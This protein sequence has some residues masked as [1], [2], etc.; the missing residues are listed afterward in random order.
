[1]SLLKA[2]FRSSLIVTDDFG[3]PYELYQDL[4]FFSAKLDREITVPKKFL[5]DL[6]SIP[7]GLWNLLPKSGRYDR[8]AVIHDWLYAKNGCTRAEADAILKEAMEALGV[9]GV[10]IWMIYSG[11]RAGGWKSWGKYRE[12]DKNENQLDSVQQVVSGDAHL[13]R[14]VEGDRETS[15]EK[16][17]A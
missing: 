8:A 12:R 15:G 7:M 14:V 10:K 16:I 2:E 17:N 3:L 5:T 11:V 13:G 4:V 1:M 6:A 9:G